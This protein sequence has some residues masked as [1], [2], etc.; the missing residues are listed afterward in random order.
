MQTVRKMIVNI[1]TECIYIRKALSMIISSYYPV[2]QTER[3]ADTA[4]FYEKH[5][6]FRSLFAADWYVHL[7]HAR[8]PEVNLAILA[9]GHP[10][11]PSCARHKSLN[12]MLLNF[13]VEDVDDA[14]RRLGEAGL[15]IA[16]ELRDEDF[17]QR[18]FIV[19][20][21][22]GVLID[23]IQPIPPSEEFAKHYA[24]GSELES[25]ERG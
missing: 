22:N 19:A 5:F 10:T 24:G 2:I 6:D 23:V 1:Q 18:H 20:D 15:C 3:V 11:I 13:E 17:G 9:A 7:Q 4:A 12:G 14:R 8:Q 25:E 16:Q 21:P